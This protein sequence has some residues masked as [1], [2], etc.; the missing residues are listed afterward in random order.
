MLIKIYLGSVLVFFI[1]AFAV[2]NIKTF[3][4]TGI[5]IRGKS[6]KLTLSIVFSTSLYLIILLRIF[7]LDSSSILE[8]ESLQND[9]LK[10]IGLVLVGIGF[11]L[12]IAALIQMRDSWRVGI[13]YDQKTALISDGIYSFSRNPYFLSYD[14]LIL[15][16][17]FIFPSPVLF[18]QYLIL[19]Y[20]F[21]TMILDEE[22]Y[23]ENTHGD[24]YRE[25]KVKVGRYFT[26]KI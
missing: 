9:I 12:G 13:K 3:I 18:I 15:G 14:V 11:I 5:S 8:I 7:F 16:Y 1:L 26:S 25:Y 17:L 4:S 24:L 2:K 10:T 21:H 19:V 22:K 23:L 20:V 6:T